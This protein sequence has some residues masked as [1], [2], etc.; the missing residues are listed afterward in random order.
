MLKTLKYLWALFIHSFIHLF[1][2]SFV[3]S[4]APPLA[5]SFINSCIYAWYSG[6][7]TLNTPLSR[8]LEG[9]PYK[10]LNESF[11]SSFVQHQ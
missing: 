6:I 9:A 7:Y 4:L 3:R 5:H 10:F 8:F 1:I 2:H 11:S